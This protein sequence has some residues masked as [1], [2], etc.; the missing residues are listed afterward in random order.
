MAVGRVE[1]FREWFKVLQHTRAYHTMLF[2]TVEFLFVFQPIVVVLHFALARWS[3]GAAVAGL[4]ASSLVFYAW[5]NPPWV[6]IPVASIL[7]NYWLATRI[8]AGDKVAGR[9]WLVLGIVGNLLVLGYFKY[10]DFLMSV[11]DGHRPAAPNV[12]LALS[13]V[14]FVQ[15]AFLV[16]IYRRRVSFDFSHYALFAA[17]F[18]HLIAGPIV[19]WNSLG[20]QLADPKRYQLDWNNVA[21]GLTI[22]IFGLCKKV[23][24]ADQL[25]PHVGVVF[26]AA[27]RGDPITTL[28]TWS[29]AFGFSAQIYFD[30]SGYSDMAVGLGLLFNFRLPINFAAP[31]R[32][33]N[34]LDFWRRWHITLTQLFRDFVYGSLT[35]GRPALLWRASCIM[36]T[37]ILVGLWHGAAWKFIVWGA[38]HGA[39]LLITLGWQMRPGAPVEL[40]RAGRLASWA[41]TMTLVAIGAVLFRAADLSTAWHMFTAMAGHGGNGSAAEAALQWDDWKMR[42]G[43]TMQSVLR[44]WLGTT[45]SVV[46]MMWTVV[47]LAIAVLLPDTMEIV[48]YREGDAQSNWRRSAGLLRWRPVFPALV[49]MTILIV[50]VFIGIGRVNEFIYYQF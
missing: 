12:P 3:P 29:A 18:P 25:A 1:V 26:A 39:L 49:A 31:F 23:L 34:L 13:F 19:R 42:F 6:V 11:V 46:G 5:W 24:I 20:R 38:Y 48:D 37:M 47:A 10:A 2:N 8:C 45:W 15:I 7:I 30:F 33:T 41:L 22:L 36:I 14:T 50:A 21:I 35:F 16:D 4:T 17:F 43:Y 32:A 27:A 40:S 44:T 9:P 28:A